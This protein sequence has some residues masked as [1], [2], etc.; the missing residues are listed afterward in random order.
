MR[1]VV[2]ALISAV[3][4]VACSSSSDGG[5][6][7]CPPGPNGAAYIFT[8]DSAVLGVHQCVE[9]YGNVP[10]SS[11]QPVCTAVSGKIL[12]GACPVQGSVGSCSNN[13]TTGSSVIEQKI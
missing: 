9:Y 12:S 4:V 3:S 7:G 11:L 13:V 1:N 8:C 2:I 6:G 10:A 5:G